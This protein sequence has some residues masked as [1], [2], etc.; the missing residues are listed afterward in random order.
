MMP[1]FDTALLK[2]QPDHLRP[3]TRAEKDAEGQVAPSRLSFRE[4]ITQVFAMAPR[5]GKV[6][7]L[8]NPMARPATGYTTARV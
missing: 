8:G 1:P 5:N 3:R 2:H 7:A 6:N 4:F